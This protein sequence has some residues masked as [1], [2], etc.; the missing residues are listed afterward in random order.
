MNPDSPD[1][2]VSDTRTRQK[3][4][5]ATLDWATE[6]GLLRLSMN[7]VAKRAR[8]ARATL[9]LHFPGKQ[10]LFDAAIDHEISELMVSVRKVIETYDAIDDRIVHGFAYTYWSINTNP[11]LQ[12]VLD[13]NPEA[14]I[15]HIIGATSTL[16]RGRDFAV[17]LARPGDIPPHLDTYMLGDFA[18][19][20]LQTLILSPP[21]SFDPQ[22]PGAV[23]YWARCFLL[24]IIHSAP[25]PSLT[26]SQHT[27]T[28][29]HDTRVP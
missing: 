1:R 25:P 3:I 14:L 9:Y 12:A 18:G 24:P 26:T 10:A 13:R 8:I 23:E 27:K 19:R 21:P 28:A 6:T 17:A 15:P 29:A 4:L 2:Q 20:L 22:R 16:N 5:R 11:I 7:G